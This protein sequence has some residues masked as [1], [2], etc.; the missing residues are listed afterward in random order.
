MPDKRSG[1]LKCLQQGGGFLRDVNLSFQ[2]GTGDVWVSQN[3]IR[4][5]KAL[6]GGWQ[7]DP[8]RLNNEIENS[9]RKEPII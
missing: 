8:K 9:K 4:I 7:P 1:V 3:M 5:Y 6:G 2:A